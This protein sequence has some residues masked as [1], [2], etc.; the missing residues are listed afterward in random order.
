[1]LEIK[2]LSA[3][4][5]GRKV[6]SDVS[7]SFCEGE[8][9]SII[10]P[11]GCGKTTLLKAVLSYIEGSGEVLL[12]GENLNKMTRG[13]RARE[14]AY[15]AQGRNIPDMTVGQLVLH[16]RFPHLSYPRRYRAEDREIARRAVEKMGLCECSDALLATLSG[17]MR[18][19][20]YIAMALAQDTKFILL[21][22]PTTYLDIKNRISL[23]NELKSL[24]DEG[25][26][27]VTVLHEIPFA[28]DYSD[29]VIVMDGGRVIASGT[30]KEIYESKIADKVF[31][32]EIKKTGESYYYGK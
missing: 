9:T 2:N 15:L 16:G 8:I 5:G 22:E 27:I 11:N 19:N 7:L 12:N 18:Q 3:G 25:K 32:I 17:G 30:P 24:A 21:D 6:L 10:G 14:I 4:Y 29:K 23:M 13:K 28:L 26:G 20:A 1:M 31:G